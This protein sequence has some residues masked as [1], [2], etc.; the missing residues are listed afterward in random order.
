MSDDLMRRLRFDL[1]VYPDKPTSVYPSDVI[2]VVDDLQARIRIL[3]ATIKGLTSHDFDADVA[4]E[5]LTKRQRRIEELEGESHDMDL[6]FKRI[7]EE[8]CPTDEV[9]CTC[10]PLLRN[11]IL[12]DI[13][14]NAEL[15][16]FVEKV[17][18]VP[19]FDGQGVYV[20]NVEIGKVSC[21]QYDWIITE[22]T[23]LIKEQKK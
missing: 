21:G 12:K 15:L 6:M 5:E 4:T 13:E 9:H 17:S 22:A 2:E 7:M 8:K 11:R 19:L 14:R 18:A 23:R 16:A 1:S 3:E 10:V 20:G